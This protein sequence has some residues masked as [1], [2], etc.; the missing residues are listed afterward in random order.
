MTLNWTSRYYSDTRDVAVVDR[1]PANV[2]AIEATL[3]A[4]DDGSRIAPGRGADLVWSPTTSLPDL[5]ALIGGARHE[6]L[7]EN[8]EMSNADIT[9]A[10]IAAARR[11][12]TVEICMTNSSSWSS[13]FA[14]LAGAG[15][16]IRVYAPDAALYIHANVIVR[17]PGSGAQ[18]AFAGSQNFSTESLR[19]NRELGVV[20]ENGTAVGQLAAMIQRDYGGASPW[21]G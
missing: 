12:V 10:L 21:N 1:I 6:L 2:A 17:D 14:A 11:G 8:E 4:D 3:N 20:L 16:H 19:Y 13:D 5:L 7:V 15:V 18:E 9:D